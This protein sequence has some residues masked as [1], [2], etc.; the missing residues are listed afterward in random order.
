MYLEVRTLQ[1]KI[2]WIGNNQ[3]TQTSSPKQI[4]HC[5]KPSLP[6]RLKV[7]SPLLGFAGPPFWLT[8]RWSSPDSCFKYASC[9]S[10]IRE[11]KVII[12]KP[13]QNRRQNLYLE[14]LN[15]NILIFQPN[16]I[17]KI[18]VRSRRCDCHWKVIQCFY[19][20]KEYLK[21]NNQN[22]GDQIL[23]RKRDS[24]LKIKEL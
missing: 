17:M 21:T 24:S 11:C 22:N 12:I 1:H 8:L 13:E 14:E 3:V 18:F 10:C 5:E 16:N 7:K 23:R 6:C 15:E 2:R 20:C 9:W 4:S 19:F